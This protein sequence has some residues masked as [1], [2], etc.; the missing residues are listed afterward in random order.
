MAGPGITPRVACG[1]HQQPVVHIRTA[2][3]SGSRELEV[4]QRKLRPFWEPTK[5]SLGKKSGAK[6]NTNRHQPQDKKEKTAR[7]LGDFTETLLN[8][9]QEIC[10]FCLVCVSHQLH[11]SHTAPVT[12]PLCRPSEKVY[13]S[14]LPRKW[15][16]CTILPSADAFVSLLCWC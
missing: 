7:E 13:C 3:P 14:Q 2:G 15:Q 10:N 4:A 5:G 16:N 6:P 1:T 12:F 8:G 11:H 9:K